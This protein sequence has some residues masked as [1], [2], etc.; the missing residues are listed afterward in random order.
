MG[1]GVGMGYNLFFN[2]FEER[3]KVLDLT[4]L[5]TLLAENLVFQSRFVF[6]EG[7]DAHT[8]PCRFVTI[9]A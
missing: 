9:D 7:D 3:D 2:L 6:V 5:E 8:I 1:L 4:L